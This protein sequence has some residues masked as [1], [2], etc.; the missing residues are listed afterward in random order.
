MPFHFFRRVPGLLRLRP[1]PG[2]WAFLATLPLALMAISFAHGLLAFGVLL[3]LLA[4]LLLV[5]AGRHRWDKSHRHA[6]WVLA[7]T[8][9]LYSILLLAKMG[10]RPQLHW[11]GFALAGPASCCAASHG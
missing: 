3:P 11:Y 7:V 9:L 6:D 1:D 8:G 10:L 4:V 5:P 2:P